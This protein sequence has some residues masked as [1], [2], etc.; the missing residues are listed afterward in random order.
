MNVVQFG[1]EKMNKVVTSKEAILEVSRNLATQQGL[2]AINM[3]TVAKECQVAL[4]SIYNYFPSKG[5]LIAATVESIWMSIF[6]MTHDCLHF[7]NFIECLKWLYQQ[8]Q[9][10]TKEYPDFLFIHP[11]G[12]DSNQ[13]ELGKAVMDKYFEHMYQNLTIVL[14]QDQNV[15]ENTFDDSLSEREF[16]QFVFSNIMDNLSQNQKDCHTLIEIVKRILY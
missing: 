11:E 15:K 5:D 6:H 3:R 12:F 1:G 16:I 4:G 9:N 2:K 13:K 10:G 14:Q 8:I 7:D